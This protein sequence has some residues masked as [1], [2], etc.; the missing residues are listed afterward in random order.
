[1]AAI[2]G[3]RYDMDVVY[4]SDSWTTIDHLVLTVLPTPF[5]HA[6]VSCPSWL[7]ITEIW[8]MCDLLVRGGPWP[9]SRR[10][11][12]VPVLKLDVK[13]P[14]RDRS[15]TSRHRRSRAGT[16]CRPCGTGG[17]IIPVTSSRLGTLSF[18]RSS[19]ERPGGLLERRQYLRVSI[20]GGFIG[21][22][23]FDLCSTP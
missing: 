20:K 13:P 6:R 1:M 10:P 7:L 16:S 11:T 2:S 9:P 8:Q 21:R 19:V 18:A 12:W 17:A 15:I 4:V 3:Y 5:H 23:P 14:A 22:R